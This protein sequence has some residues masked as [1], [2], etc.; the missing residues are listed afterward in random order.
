MPTP[1]RLAFFD[2]DG[3]LK[4]AR[5]PYAYLH[6]HL[7]FSAQCAEYAAAF[8]RGEIDYGEWLR[9]DV[10]LW[11]GLP[12]GRIEALLRANPYLPGAPAF[13]RALVA[14][15]VTTIIITTGPD[16][17]ARMVA[18]E[19]GVHHFHANIISVADGVLTGASETHVAEGA[20]GRLVESYQARYGI[21]PARCL[22]IGDT[23]SDV[24]MFQR[25][26]MSVAVNPSAPAV[27]AAARIVLP[28]PDLTPLPELLR[29]LEP[30]WLEED[31]ARYAARSA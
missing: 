29:R 14:A 4:A 9:R 2:L 12:A 10:A 22:A 11:K 31:T 20:K 17:H 18:S 6:E 19:L 7:G 21:A 5:S 30:A 15:G 27:A 23:P 28:T 13:V 1:S 16:L 25:V 8:Y 24:D 3:T 26:G